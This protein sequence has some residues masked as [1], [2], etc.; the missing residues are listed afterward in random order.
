VKDDSLYLAHI[1]DAVERI[2][3]YAGEGEAAFRKDLRTQD[4]IIRNLQVMGEAAKKVSVRT[5]EDHPG[6]PW[7]D[8]TWN[9]RPGGSRLFR[10]LPRHRVGRC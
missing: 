6:V 8:I 7:K 1:L 2:L 9:A 5:R 3:S 4:A 10:R